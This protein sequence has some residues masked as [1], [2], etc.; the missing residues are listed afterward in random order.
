MRWYKGIN[1]CFKLFDWDNGIDNEYN[2]LSNKFWS[3]NIKFVDLEKCAESYFKSCV[4]KRNGDE[5]YMELPIHFKSEFFADGSS[6]ITAIS[7]IKDG[8]FYYLDIS[9]ID[10][11]YNLLVCDNSQI[12]RLADD[13][14]KMIFINELN[15]LPEKE[16]NDFS[17]IIEKIKIGLLQANTIGAVKK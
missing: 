9:N 17:E 10:S 13:T 16:K 7:F 8:V 1:E 5:S 2:R 14:E 4:A 12:Q 15:N 11:N 3:S 6:K